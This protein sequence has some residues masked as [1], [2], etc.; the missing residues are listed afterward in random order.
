[1]APTRRIVLDVLKPH[2]PSLVE[3]AQDVADSEGVEGVNA[4]VLEVDEEVQ[5]V[6]LTVEGTDIEFDGLKELVEDKGGSVHSID[7]IVC[8][9]RMVEES[10][11][12]QD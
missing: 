3:F 2:Q 12:P 1:M 9:D 5:N 7:E 11:T 6:K 4:I 8:G 10:E